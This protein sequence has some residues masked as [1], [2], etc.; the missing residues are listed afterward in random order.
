MRA[1]FIDDLLTPPVAEMD[2]LDQE[3]YLRHRYC[4]ID[5]MVEA[6]QHKEHGDADATTAAMRDAR[7]ERDAARA[8]LRRAKC[9]AD[10]GGAG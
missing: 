4:A 7:C 10:Q 3:L 8:L 9:K 2:R 5:R 6:R 1:V